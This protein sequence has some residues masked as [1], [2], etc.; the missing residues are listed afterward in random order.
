MR[1]IIPTDSSLYRAVHRL[2]DTFREECCPKDWRVLPFDLAREGSE[3][4]L[5]VRDETFTARE[6]KG[7]LSGFMLLCGRYFGATLPEA[8]YRKTPVFLRG[9]ESA[10]A[11]AVET[12]A[13]DAL[14]EAALLMDMRGEGEEAIFILRRA[15]LG[16]RYRLFSGSATVGHPIPADA[17]PALV[18]ALLRV[19]ALPGLFGSQK[20]WTFFTA[21]KL[22]MPYLGHSD[23]LERAIAVTKVEEL[24]E[25]PNV[26]RPLEELADMV[27]PLLCGLAYDEN[28]FVRERALAS[29]EVM[30]KRLFYD[31]RENWRRLLPAVEPLL[32]A[33]VYPELQLERRFAC[34][35]W[36]GDDNGAREDMH[37]RLEL[38]QTLSPELVAFFEKEITARGRPLTAEP[39]SSKSPPQ[40]PATP[41]SPTTSGEP[42]A[43]M[44]SQP[45]RPTASA[46]KPRGK[47]TPVA[48]IDPA[49]FVALMVTSVR[50]DLVRAVLAGPR[51][52]ELC[53][54]LNISI[55]GVPGGP[56]SSIFSGP[57]YSLRRTG[58]VPHALEIYR[59]LDRAYA[60]KKRPKALVDLVAEIAEEQAEDRRSIWFDVREIFDDATGRQRQRFQEAL[61][62]QAEGADLTNMGLP[63]GG[64]RYRAQGDRAEK[65]AALFQQAFASGMGPALAHALF[66]MLPQCLKAEQ[67]LQPLPRAPRFKAALFVG[68]M[69]AD[70]R[71]AEF[72]ID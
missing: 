4:I 3:L 61:V 42:S 35:L 39:I 70:V 17:S 28:A 47:R 18:K 30:G 26:W 57:V 1:E 38:E 65:L 5:T 63:F 6:I 69:F 7:R 8:I 66:D 33:G 2:L 9:I 44:D 53:V 56:P 20:S 59:R 64:Q 12:K 23:A 55:S 19:S 31:V 60:A 68:A 58:D 14:I 37:A 34:R 50:E 15:A 32:A 43:P 21:M 13:R 54:K 71:S 46:A 62:R 11:S 52:S 24:L 67:V 29:L 48:P 45:S 41:M 22:A 27:G 25:D 49:E 36:S 51:A 16:C 72:S 10:S 40:P